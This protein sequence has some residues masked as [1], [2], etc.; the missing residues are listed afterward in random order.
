FGAEAPLP[1]LRHPEFQLSH[2][3]HQRPSLIARAVALAVGGAFALLGTHGFIHLPFQHLPDNLLDQ[4]PQKILL[5][6][7]PLFPVGSFRVILLSGHLLL[8]F[9]SAAN[10]MLKGLACP[11]SI[12]R[13]SAA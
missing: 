1:I 13:T 8:S 2:P 12:C 9:L 7:H 10:G 6:R 4:R 3:R 11:K 5:P